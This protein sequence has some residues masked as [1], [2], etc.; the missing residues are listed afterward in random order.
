MNDRDS[1]ETMMRANGPRVYTLAIRLTGNESDGQD[2]AQEAFV[3]AFEHWAD[4]RGEADVATWLYRICVNCW[5]NRVRYERRRSFWK[6]FSIDGNSAEDDDSTIELPSGE[7]AIDQPLEK[8]EELKAL[9]RALGRLE[10]HERAIL[11]LREMENRS[12]EEIADLLDIPIGT[13]RSRLAR[14]RDKLREL[15]E[16]E[17]EK[18]S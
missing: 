1:F 18:T 11:V 4:F 12:Y 2:L 3:K 10:S 6:H 14:T 9:H 5:K 16:T 17:S 8:A 15:I 7:A 13:V